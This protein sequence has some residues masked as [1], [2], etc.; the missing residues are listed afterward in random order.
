MKQSA[1][2]LTMMLAV[3]NIFAEW[4]YDSV[5]KTATDGV[6]VLKFTEGSSSRTL[7][8]GSGTDGSAVESGSG[9]LDLSSFQVDTGYE[10]IAVSAYS[11]KG[12]PIT[13]FTSPTV[14]EIGQAA[15]HTNDTIET[16]NCPNVIKI[17]M[18]GFRTATALKSVVISPDVKEIVK[19]S[20]DGTTAL[21]DFSPRTF[22]ALKTVEDQLFQ[23]SAISG[24]L[25]FPVATTVKGKAFYG[26]ANLTELEFPSVTSIGGEAFSKT[27]S[28]KKMVWSEALAE[29]GGLVFYPSCAVET[30]IPTKFPNLASVSSQTFSGAKFLKGDFEFPLLTTI[31][32]NFFNGCNSINSIKAVSATRICKGSTQAFNNCLSMTSAV[33]SASLEAIGGSAFKGCTML[34]HFEPYLPDTLTSL[35]SS[36]F[37]SCPALTKPPKF[38]SKNLTTIGSSAFSDTVKSWKDPVDIYSPI[39][40]I[41]QQAFWACN[42]GQ[43]FNFYADVA[44]LPL[45]KNSIICASRADKLDGMAVLCVKSRK[46]LP[47]WESE[48][49]ANS[50]VF[51][52]LKSR[53]DFPAGRVIGVVSVLDGSNKKKYN[54]VVD[55]TPPA[56]SVI[57]MM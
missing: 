36:A 42:F 41:G 18:S 38:I 9:N 6:W 4:E 22:L 1:L 33:F 21:T 15:F 34:A 48:C 20:F 11:F 5:E 45:V 57:L 27:L 44:P 52:S 30:L 55:D 54:W 32:Q 26:C 40:T 13:S 46:A 28:L 7:V 37:A 25:S 47:A 10:I 14:T 51:E 43:V 49:A 16:L 19:Y 35:E 50:E 3:G 31:P 56:G 24:K 39:S 2:I 12:V 53:D 23:N 29:V 8:L 17:A